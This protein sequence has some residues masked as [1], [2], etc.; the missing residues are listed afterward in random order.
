M[1]EQ[2]APDEAMR[3]A[4]VTVEQ[5]AFEWVHEHGQEMSALH[6]PDA[7]SGHKAVRAA[8]RRYALAVLCDP[9]SLADRIAELDAEVGE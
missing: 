7:Q 6:E 5:H 1:S 4:L 8:I 2:M 3:V 9:R